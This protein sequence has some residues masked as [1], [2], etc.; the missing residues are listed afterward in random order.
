VANYGVFANLTADFVASAILMPSLALTLLAQG[1]GL[2]ASTASP[3]LWLAGTA[4]KT[5]IAIGHL[6]TFAPGAATSISSAPELAL[7]ISYLA[8]V[9]ACLWQGRLR[10]VG[11][12]LSAA[13]ALWPRPA[14][15]VAW[16]AADGD[17]AAVVV[18]GQ[19]VAMKPGARR[20]ATQLWAQ[21]RGL[22]PPDDPA[23]AR[24]D[25]FQCDRRGCMPVGRV[26]PAL[27]ASWMHKPPNEERFRQL[28][29]GADIVVLRSRTTPDQRCGGA[30]V[31]T[32]GDFERNGAA[33]VFADGPGWRIAWTQ[34]ARGRR[35]WTGPYGPPTGSAE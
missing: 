19:E 29:D 4:A 32:R 6:F 9:F 34:P 10:W 14:A 3:V 8:I 30:T 13:V 31:L 20:Y 17:D 12:P 23:V 16:I 26:R 7:A 35:P 22:T 28:C 27:S 25:V 33:E 18:N 15:P 5:I 11:L 1:M 2:D 24:P 21:R